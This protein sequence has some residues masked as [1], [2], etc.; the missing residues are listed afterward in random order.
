[1]ARILVETAFWLAMG[2][3]IQR[4]TNSDSGGTGQD[5]GR[6]TGQYQ[7][8]IRENQNVRR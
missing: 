8:E 5:T 3:H 1:M 7:K 2:T 4:A 6:R